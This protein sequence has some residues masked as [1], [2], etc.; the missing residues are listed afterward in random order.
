MVFPQ[1]CGDYGKV[2][3]QHLSRAIPRPPPWLG[4]GGAV[5]TN[6]KCII[7]LCSENKGADLLH[8]YHAADLR[9]SHMPKA[10]VP[11]T[12]LKFA[13]FYIRTDAV[14]TH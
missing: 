2:K 12:Q 13:K 1:H 3:T 4:G 11:M 8:G 5:V 7:Y 10:G 6:D 9:F 14:C